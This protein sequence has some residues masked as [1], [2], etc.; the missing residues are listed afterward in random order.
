M[1]AVR[2][3]V[4]GSADCRMDNFAKRSKI[5]MQNICMECEDASSGHNLIV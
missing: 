1:T 3:V 2:Y 5:A 4:C